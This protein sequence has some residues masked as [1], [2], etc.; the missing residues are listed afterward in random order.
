MK[1]KSSYI[2][3]DDSPPGARELAV[4]RTKE[5]IRHYGENILHMPIEALAASCYLQGI[6]DAIHVEM[7]VTGTITAS[8]ITLTHELPKP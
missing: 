3:P 1:R 6:R 7:R 2:I 5:L 8:G 4:S